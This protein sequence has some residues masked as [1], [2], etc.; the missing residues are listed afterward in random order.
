MEERESGN[1]GQW[2]GAAPHSPTPQ[3]IAGRLFS[4]PPHA[5]SS[6]W[7]GPR[8]LTL[9]WSRS[10]RQTPTRRCLWGWCTGCCPRRSRWS[11]AA[12]SPSPSPELGLDRDTG[13]VRTRGP[14]ESGPQTRSTAPDLLDSAPDTPL[15]ITTETSPGL[16]VRLQVN[17]CTRGGTQTDVACIDLFLNQLY[18]GGFIPPVS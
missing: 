8:A 14:P 3:N 9:S 18:T 2:L 1:G 11:G 5:A 15:S 4:W 16:R 10:R 13:G 17:V 7:G 6:C 12:R